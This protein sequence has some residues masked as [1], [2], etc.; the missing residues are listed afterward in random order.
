MCLKVK[1]EPYSSVFNYLE[2]GI[3]VSEMEVHDDIDEECSIN[4][5][6][7]GNNPSRVLIVHK[8]QDVG[9]EDSSENEHS[10]VN[11]TYKVMK[12][13]HLVRIGSS[14]YIT[15]GTLYF[16]VLE[17]CSSSSTIRVFCLKNVCFR[18]KCCASFSFY[19]SLPCSLLFE[20]P[21][22]GV[23]YAIEKVLLIRS[24]MFNF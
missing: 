17:M 12:A 2:F 3:V 16:R 24:N 21:A 23:V 11:I 10:K 18:L 7:Q 20:M 9:S 5:G 13:C 19:L 22:F 8:A 4:H 1:A 6:F 14:G 15:P